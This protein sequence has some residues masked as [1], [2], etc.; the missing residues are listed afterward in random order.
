M[1][2][3]KVGE[4]VVLKNIF[5]ETNAFVLKTESDVEIN[6]LLGFM[7]KNSNVSIEI[8]GHT[9]N[10]GDAKYNQTLS[11]KRAKSVYDNLIAAGIV[12]T[13]LSYKGYGDTKPIADNTTDEGK[14]QNRRTEFMITH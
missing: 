13:R 7:Q 11:E 1:S 10:V 12:A 14:Q 2:K 9:D 6:K 4:T 5:F 8:S 3:V